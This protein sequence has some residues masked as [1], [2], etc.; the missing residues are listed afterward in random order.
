[1]IKFDMVVDNQNN[2]GNDDND[3]DDMKW[4]M[5]SSGPNYSGFLSIT[6]TLVPFY[7]SLHTPF[8]VQAHIMLKIPP[9]IE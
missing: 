7:W 4:K 8:L 9:K 1:M 2:A 3:Y 5:E 6:G